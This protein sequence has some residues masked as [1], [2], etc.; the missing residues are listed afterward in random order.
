MRKSKKQ[1]PSDSSI[2]STSEKRIDLSSLKDFVIEKLPPDS[3]VRALILEEG[4]SLPAQEFVTKVE[5]WLK[6]LRRDK[7]SLL[8]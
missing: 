4:G 5:V 6:L 3:I 2:S 8:T 7:A 1:D